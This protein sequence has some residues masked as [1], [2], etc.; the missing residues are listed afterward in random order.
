MRETTRRNLIKGVSAVT[1]SLMTKTTDLGALQPGPANAKAADFFPGFEKRNIETSETTIHCVIGGRGPAV[2]LLHGYPQTHATWRKVAGRL[3]QEFTVIAPDLRGYGASSKP[4]DGEN[5]SGYSKRAMAKDQIEVMGQLGFK[6]FAVVGHDRGG[7]VG[8]RM[9][10]D[11]ADSVKRLAVLDIVP[12]YKLYTHVT[13]EF[14]TVYYHWF[15]LIQPAPFPETVISNSL[16]A[17]LFGGEAPAWMG[18]TAYREYREAFRDAKTLHASCEDYRAGASID[19]EH[20]GADL[21][22]KIECPFLALW[23]ARGA[24]HQLYDV[25]DTW[26]ERAKEVRG[27]ALECGHFLP[28]EAPE[29]LL[30]ELLPFLRE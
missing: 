14:A 24:M 5:H 8:H 30:A 6:S 7:R 11:Y 12:T 25:A 1:A 22:R 16:D 13:K 26:K 29:A 10:L 2:L 3:A 15:F 21:S 4:A 17:F 19:L 27:K 18:D 20:D 28:E 23:G 9:A